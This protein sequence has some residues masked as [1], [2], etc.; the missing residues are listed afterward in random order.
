MGFRKNRLDI[1]KQKK[2]RHNTTKNPDYVKY[3][4][5]FEIYLFFVYYQWHQFGPT[6]N[7]RAIL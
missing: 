2:F 7:C 3:I 1:L 5:T 4:F 6:E